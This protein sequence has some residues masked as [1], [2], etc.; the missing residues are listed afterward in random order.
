M[1]K[2][3]KYPGL[4]IVHGKKGISYG[5]DY[6]NPMTNQRVRKILKNVTSAEDAAA[7]RAIEIADAKRGDI[8]NTSSMYARAFFEHF[9]FEHFD[10][11]FLDIVNSIDDLKP[12]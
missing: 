4:Y 12:I 11:D 5:I 3:K 2:S 9:D 6:I 1:A 7:I 10:F 8:G